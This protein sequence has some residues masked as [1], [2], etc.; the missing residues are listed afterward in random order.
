MATSQQLREIHKDMKLNENSKKMEKEIIKSVIN[1]YEKL[2]FEYPNIEFKFESKM[3]LRDMIDNLNDNG[4]EGKNPY[5][6]PDGGF[7]FAKIKNNWK[8]I[9]ISE[10]KKQ[11]TNDI[12]LRE[13]MKK[14]SKGN[15]IERL[16]KNVIGIQTWLIN[17]GIFP[18]VCFG[19]GCDFDEGSSIRDRVVTINQFGKL[20]EIYV[21]RINNLQRGSYFFRYE[22]WTHEKMIPI[23]YEVARRSLSFYGK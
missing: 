22:K 6:I 7:I 19:E 13:G 21:E 18:F 9:L 17:E 10:A 8:V 23:L 4:I 14:Q 15:A 11:G 16:G 20:N 5:I 2:K 1:V 3:Y 12:R